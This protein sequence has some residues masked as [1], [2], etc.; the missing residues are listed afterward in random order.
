MKKLFLNFALLISF[1]VFSQ[2]ATPFVV[3][4]CTDK[5]T[6]IEYYFP[7]KKLVCSNTEK[8]K[9]FIISP[10]FKKEESGLA[11]SG[12]MCENVAIGSC[13]ENDILII[14]FEDDT[15]ITL[16]SWNKF[17]CEGYS[18][19]HFT[20]SELTELSVKKMKSIRF[21]NGYSYDNLTV[22]LKADQKDY[23]IRAYTNNKV[24]EINC[25]N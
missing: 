19:Y 21:T 25:S 2:K 11:Y 15:K 5:M 14:L 23:F 17:N 6:D 1:S 7:E 4:H 10:N 24:V 9:G 22:V 20:D 3:E 12:L 16:T 13:D 8:T 18:Y